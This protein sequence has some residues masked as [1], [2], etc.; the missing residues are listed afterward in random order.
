MALVDA[1]SAQS[2]NRNVQQRHLQLTAMNRILGS[3]VAGGTAA[4]LAPDLLSELVEKGQ[5]GGLDAVF[6]QRAFQTQAAQLRTG[7]RQQVDADAQRPDLPHGFI[8]VD[9]DAALVQHQ[10]QAQAADTG[11]G[12]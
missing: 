4:R 2:R 10:R 6:R 5:R 8:H 12:D 9:L 11:A 3:G 1:V 7:V